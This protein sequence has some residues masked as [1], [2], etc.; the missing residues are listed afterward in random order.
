MPEGDT[1]H[2]IA[3]FLAPRLEGRVVVEV[4]MAD[5]EGARACS[6]RRVTFVQARG[7]H[8]YIGFDGEEVLRSHLGMYGSWHFYRPDEAW[9]KPRRQASLVVATA[10]EVFVCF[11]AR[12]VELLRSPSVRARIG[13]T[14]LG[15]D[16]IADGA[17]PEIIVR[18]ARDLLD[19]D[20]LL[21]DVLLDQRVA[22]GI[23]NVYKSE[24]LFLEGWSPRTRLGEVADADLARCFATAADLL[25]RNLGGGRR[26]TRFAADRAG[27][28]WVYGRTGKPCLRCETPVIGG[29]LGRHHR[30]TYWCPGCQ[31]R[32]RSEK[33]VPA[34]GVSAG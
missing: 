21:A 11:N 15:P 19:E 20:A 14:R 1:V 12:E 29:R 4:R 7:K 16:L 33:R 8:L 13:Q 25:G 18:R 9:R 22:C 32:L 6:G 2:K 31:S 17:G 10:D 30:S 34:P 24:V 28:L 26:V 3:N 23:G 27:R 5:A